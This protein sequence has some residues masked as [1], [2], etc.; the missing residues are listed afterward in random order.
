MLYYTTKI[1][2]IQGFYLHNAKLYMTVY[3]GGDSVDID[4]YLFSKSAII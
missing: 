4:I 2:N 3:V 1:Y